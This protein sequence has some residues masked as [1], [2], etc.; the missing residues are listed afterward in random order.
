MQSEQKTTHTAL[1]ALAG[2]C[3]ALEREATRMR[4]H[5]A[6]SPPSSQTSN[7]TPSKANMTISTDAGSSTGVTSAA[8]QDSHL[9][10]PVALKRDILEMPDPGSYHVM[11]CNHADLSTLSRTALLRPWRP[12]LSFRPRKRRIAIHNCNFHTFCN[13]YSHPILQSDASPIHGI[14]CSQSSHEFM[15][16]T[17]ERISRVAKFD[18]TLHVQIM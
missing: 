14:G 9:P 15:M 7:R 12:C 3:T 5:S 16:F 8:V 4:K 17:E 13:E 6:I 18:V 11:R 10:K 2:K 1:R